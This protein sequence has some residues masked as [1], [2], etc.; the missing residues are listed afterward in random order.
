MALDSESIVMA[1]WGYYD[2]SVGFRFR[3][4]IFNLLVQRLF[5]FDLKSCLV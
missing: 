2:T 3:R 5:L 4:V 1:L